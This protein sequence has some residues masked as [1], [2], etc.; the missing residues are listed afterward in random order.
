MIAGL[1]VQGTS[2]ASRSHVSH[3]YCNYTTKQTSQS[4]LEPL[5]HLPLPL[6]AELLAGHHVVDGL[7]HGVL[8]EVVV[9]GG[10]LHDEPGS[11]DRRADG[12]AL[13]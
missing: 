10:H 4:G 7:E 13:V 9:A 3:S 8:A 1:P 6:V 2:M 11:A 12:H 5:H